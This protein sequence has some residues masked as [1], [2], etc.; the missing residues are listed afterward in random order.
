MMMKRAKEYVAEAW[1]MEATEE[2]LSANAGDEC[3]VLAM[4]INQWAEDAEDED[5]EPVP[6]DIMAWARTITDATR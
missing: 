4:T 1:G 3:L 6:A 2:W 5:G